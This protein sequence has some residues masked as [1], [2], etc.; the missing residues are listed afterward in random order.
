MM[1]V[2]MR[3]DLS[4]DRSATMSARYIVQS[5]VITANS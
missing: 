2:L 5:Q 4:K 1:K 3:T